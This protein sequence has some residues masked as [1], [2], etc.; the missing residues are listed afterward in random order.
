MLSDC[1]FFFA[2][3]LFTKIPHIITALGDWLT[4]PKWIGTHT[5]DCLPEVAVRMSLRCEKHHPLCDQLFMTGHK[6]GSE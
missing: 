2:Q 6:E 5:K 4:N 3:K 1:C